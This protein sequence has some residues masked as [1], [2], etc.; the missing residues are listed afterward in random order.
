MGL[1]LEF[2]YENEDQLN[3]L[4]YYEWMLELDNFVELL[5]S[6]SNRFG[7]FVLNKNK[8]SAINLTMYYLSYNT[9]FL[10]F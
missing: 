7:P 9:H 3:G 6:Y 8:I 5:L 10:E 2:L 1:I 4:T